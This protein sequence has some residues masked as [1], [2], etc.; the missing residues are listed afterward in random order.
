M[1]KVCYSCKETKEFSLFRKNKGTK[2]GFTASCKR[3]LNAVR[4]AYYKANPEKNRERS[5]KQ[6]Y[7]L[8]MQ[9]LELLYKEQKGSCAICGKHLE[10]YSKDKT[11]SLDVARVDHDHTTGKVRGL[12]CNHCNIGI[13][14]MKDNVVLLRNAVKYLEEFESSD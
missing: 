14:H 1:T 6:H 5:I 11:A 3:C 8:S 9:Q 2:D 12:L 4:D 13:G 7:G 10:L